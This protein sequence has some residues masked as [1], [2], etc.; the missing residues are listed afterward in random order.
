[1]KYNIYF[2][3]YEAQNASLQIFNFAHP[4]AVSALAL[5]LEIP[6]VFADLALKPMRVLKREWPRSFSMLRLL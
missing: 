1:M 3:E 6:L 2:S 5:Q 4:L